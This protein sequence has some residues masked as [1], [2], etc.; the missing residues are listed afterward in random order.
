M[1]STQVTGAGT[2]ALT[3]DSPTPSVF[4]L[5]VTDASGRLVAERRLHELHS[6]LALPQ[7]DLRLTVTDDRPLHDP[8]RHA[9]TCVDVTVG[10]GTTDVALGLTRGAVVRATSTPWAHVALV[11]ADGE[12]LD[13]RA[14]GHGVA[15]V[16]GLRAGAWTATARDARRERCSETARIIISTPGQHDVDLPTTTATARL[17]VRVGGADRRPVAATAVE[18]TD[19]AGRRVTAPVRDG[20]ADLR[21]LRP[22]RLRVVVPPSVG[23]LGTTLDLELAAGEHGTVDAVVPVGAAVTG[24]V[25]QG[26]RGR[27]QYAAVVA[28][29]DDDGVELERVRTDRSGRFVLGTGL[30]R[31]EGLTVV[32]TTGPDTLHVTRAAVAD[33]DVLNAV[34][35]DVGDVVLPVAGPRAVWTARTPAVAGMKLPSTHV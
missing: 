32:A 7:G 12:R 29:V 30:T 4:R 15:T 16:A 34:R 33:V 31:S 11:H 14:D 2:A 6:T 26:R 27:R 23:H 3:L 17:L 20:L 22:G 8:R 19:T 35:H 9:G 1:Y 10:R 5:R 24:R 28:L 21:S 18:I 25:V 13:V